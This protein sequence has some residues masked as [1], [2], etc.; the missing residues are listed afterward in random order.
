[1]KTDI[2]LEKDE[3]IGQIKSNMRAVKKG[4]DIDF[5][6][7][8]VYEVVKDHI[9][10]LVD[11]Y[12]ICDVNLPNGKDKVSQAIENMKRLAHPVID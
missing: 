6:S 5:R 4:S 3:I 9:L 8:V 2:S 7:E 1:M 11:E 12:I 10:F